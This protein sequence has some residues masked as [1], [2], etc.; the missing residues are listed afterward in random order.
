MQNF[1][2]G[3]RVDL[4]AWDWSVAASNLNSN[5]R[6]KTEITA[7]AGWQPTKLEARAGVSY[8]Y[9]AKG[10]WKT[11]SAGQPVSADGNKSDRGKLIGVILHDFQLEGPFDLASRGSFVAAGHRS[12]VSSLQRQLDGIGR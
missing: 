9:A 4:C 12:I 10:T 2:N 1:G 7:Q 8:D 5:G 3:Y 6:M 11:F